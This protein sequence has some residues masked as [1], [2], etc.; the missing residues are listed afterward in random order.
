MCPG[1]AACDNGVCGPPGTA[2]TG[3]TGGAN[4]GGTA[5]VIIAGTSNAGTIGNG[6]SSAASGGGG[7]DDQDD[8]IGTPPAGDPGCACATVG[9]RDASGLLSLLAAVLAGALG[10]RRRQR[11]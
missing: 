7:G 4:T 8:G 10:L 11:A 5:G 6:G 2:G 1:G 3:G 9:S